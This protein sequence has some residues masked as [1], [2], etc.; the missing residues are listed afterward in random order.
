MDNIVKNEIKSPDQRS[1]V[2]LGLDNMEIEQIK[3]EV[4]KPKEDSLDIVI[5]FR[6]IEDV[7]GLIESVSGLESKD[8]LKRRIYD[9]YL[10]LAIMKKMRELE[11]DISGRLSFVNLETKESE[12]SGYD[13]ITFLGGEFIDIYEV[14]YLLKKIRD[15][16]EV[17][18]IIH[19]FLD[20]VEDPK[21]QESINYLMTSKEVK[22]IAYSTK[23]KLLTDNLPVGLKMKDHDLTVYEKETFVKKYA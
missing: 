10:S 3:T 1:A 23:P 19:L 13:L 18:T 22:V 7:K 16:D 9:D 4:S 11:W 14:L 6:N 15:K 20:Y 21:L 12:L 5:D 2:F 8:D 17:P